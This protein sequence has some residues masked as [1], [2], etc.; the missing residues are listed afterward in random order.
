[1]FVLVSNHHSSKQLFE[2]SPVSL[3]NNWSYNTIHAFLGVNST[4]RNGLIYEEQCIGLCPKSVLLRQAG[5]REKWKDIMKF[6]AYNMFWKIPGKGSPQMQFSHLYAVLVE[7][8]GC[9]MS[10]HRLAWEL[11][12]TL[13]LDSMQMDTG[14]DTAMT[15]LL[16]MLVFLHISGTADLGFNF[17]FG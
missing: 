2:S 17:R 16:G 5:A 3:N 10:W 12:S 8:I 6:W 4:E 14:E 11:A 7:I 15:F 9:K 1:M 13:P